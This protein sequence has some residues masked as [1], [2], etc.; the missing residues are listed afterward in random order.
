MRP[1][2]THLRY[3]LMP[4]A[5]GRVSDSYAAA[6]LARQAVSHKR[7]A[8]QRF[9]GCPR[10]RE[11]V[12]EGTNSVDKSISD[13][14]QTYCGHLRMYN[15]TAV[16]LHRATFSFAFAFT[17]NA[18]CTCATHPGPTKQPTTCIVYTCGRQPPRAAT[19]PRIITRR[20]GP[21]P[22]CGR[23]LTAWPPPR[24]CQPPLRPRALTTWP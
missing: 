21:A 14:L 19:Q 15:G 10:R 22:G 20:R 23:P 3:L 9:V 7:P 8:D 4:H 5:A 2:A 16:Q 12:V 18:R 24:C 11:P 17:T 1:K 13:D 6:A